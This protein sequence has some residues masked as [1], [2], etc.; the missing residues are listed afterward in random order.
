MTGNVFFEQ[1]NCYQKGSFT[2]V[3]PKGSQKGKRMFWIVTGILAAVVIWLY[4]RTNVLQ[5]GE[6]AAR[7][8]ATQLERRLEAANPKGQLDVVISD[9]EKEINSG[10]KVLAT[11]QGHFNT[12]NRRVDSLV[13]DVAAWET[14]ARDLANAA[15]SEQ[16]SA[17]ADQ[18]M[19]AAREAALQVV[20][21]R[22]QLAVA[23][24][25]RDNAQG[26][27]SAATEILKAANQRLEKAK[28]QADSLGVTL[29]LARMNNQVRESLGSIAVGGEGS[30]LGSIGD[31]VEQV[32]RAIDQEK[33]RA[34]IATALTPGSE[35]AKIL[36]EFEAGRRDSEAD[37]LL[38]SLLEPA[39]PASTPAA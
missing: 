37:A 17:R 16:D 39:E 18:L 11:A 2:N 22:E 26:E 9:A 25:A 38:Q 24:E 36:A 31:A 13:N 6:R 19:Q 27:V 32:Q 7:A 30:A 14:K 21:K 20:S 10:A 12:A 3:D 35:T 33:A 1:G 29:D 5:K 8:S 23:Q 4:L 15:K 34:D 28:Q